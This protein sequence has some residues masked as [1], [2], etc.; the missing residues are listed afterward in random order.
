MNFTVVINFAGLKKLLSGVIHLARKIFAAFI[1][2]LSFSFCAWGADSEKVLARVGS[3]DITEAEVLEFIQPFGQQ[4][5]MLYGTEQGRK[6][7]LDDVIAMRLYALDAQDSKLDQTPEFQA[8]LLNAKRAMLAQVAMQKAVEGLK[9]SDEEAKKF[10]DS[11][12]A[13]FKQPERVHAR[14]ILVSGDEEL[15]KVQSEL[16]DGK[17]FDVVA[18]EYSRDPGSAANGGDLGEFPRGMMVPEFEKAAFELKNP[19]DVSEP[20]KTQFG[21]HIIKLEE[22]IPESVM[23]FEQVKDRLTNELKDQK[24]QTVLQDKAKELESKYKV[25]RLTD[26][27]KEETSPDKK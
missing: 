1:L 11:N 18:K 6:M 14:H 22:R 16:K 8:Q 26:K 3:E 19:G 25:E 17:S 15:A 23:P 21:W 4:A 27:P 7:I 20:V 13:M 24:T 9:I 12:T 5:V 2:V 10:Y